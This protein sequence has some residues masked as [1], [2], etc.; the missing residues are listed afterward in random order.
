MR[1]RSIRIFFALNISRWNE[2]FWLWS[3]MYVHYCDW[4][5]SLY[6]SRYTC[7]GPPHI[8]AWMVRISLLNDANLWIYRLWTQKFRK[9]INSIIWACTDLDTQIRLLQLIETALL[10]KDNASGRS[11]LR[12]NLNA[13][14]ALA[15]YNY[16]K[17]NT[18]QI[19]IYTVLLLG[20]IYCIWELLTARHLV[21]CPVSTF[22]D[23]ILFQYP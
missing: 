12:H 15:I 1:K 10:I 19:S 21:T 9:Y 17:I 6:H 16:W 23:G 20:L 7:T 18:Y 2:R 3:D 13:R 22:K 8:N 5:S 11:N 14:A 4:S